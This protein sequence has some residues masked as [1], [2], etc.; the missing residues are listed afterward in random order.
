MAQ[1]TSTTFLGPFFVPFPFPPSFRSPPPSLRFPPPLFRFPPPLFRFPPPLFR[2]PPPSFHS[3]RP[4]VL[5][6][7]PASKELAGMGRVV[8]GAETVPLLCFLVSRRLV[9]PVV[10]RCTRS[11]PASSC[12]RRWS[13]VL[14]WWLCRRRRSL[15]MSSSSSSSSVV[16]FNT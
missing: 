12:S 6:I 3:R 10:W 5:T 11:H 1:G 9:R 2:C 7:H 16:L 4:V 14:T 15:G 8:L 13:W